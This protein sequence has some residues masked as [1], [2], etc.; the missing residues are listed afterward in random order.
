MLCFNLNGLS[1]LTIS[2]LQASGSTCGAARAVPS[3]LRQAGSSGN[4]SYF[5]A[6]GATLSTRD[7]DELHDSLWAVYWHSCAALL[8]FIRLAVLWPPPARGARASLLGG[9]VLDDTLRTALQVITKDDV[10][11]WPSLSEPVKACTF[12][13]NCASR[14]VLR[15]V[16]ACFANLDVIKSC[17]CC[18]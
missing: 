17:A 16:T 2:G 7:N 4:V 1:K 13:P 11:L 10:S 5:A 18:F 14:P 3:Y 6:K 15:D 9:R 8:P 12:A